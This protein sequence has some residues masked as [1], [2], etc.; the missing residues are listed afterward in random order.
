MKIPFEKINFSPFP[1]E[2]NNK[3]IV[4]KGFLKKVNSKTIEFQGHIGGSINYNC[5]RCAKDMILKMDE[6][7]NLLISDGIYKDINNELT[8][9]I[10]FF[11]GNVDLD[12][13]LN[14]EIE[15]YKSGYFY[16]DECKNL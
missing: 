11:D 6:N 9:M 5:D 12:E 15:A 8:D 3:S 1:I 2:I 10:E 4:M 16:C 13:I 7:L 14:S